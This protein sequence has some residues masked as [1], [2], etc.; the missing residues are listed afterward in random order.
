MAKCPSRKKDGPPF[1]RS[2][3]PVHFVDTDNIMHL[4]PVP[5]FQNGPW[6][7]PLGKKE[8]LVCVHETM[9]VPKLE[10]ELRGPLVLS[11]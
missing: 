3:S 6:C 8:G 2:T 7:V 10:I 1:I 5:C 4:Y 11:S 9:M